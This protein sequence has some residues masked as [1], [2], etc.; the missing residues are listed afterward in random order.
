MDAL[1]KLM[2][3]KIIFAGTTEFAVTSLDKLMQSSHQVV[4]VYTQPDRPAGRGLKL[5]AS[6]I[7][8]AALAY[9]L[10]LYQPANFKEAQTQATLKALGAD[11]MVVVVY[12]LLLPQAVLET[13]RF[14]CV[15]LHPSLLP[16]WRGAAPVVRAIEAGDTETGVTIMQ[17]D[18]GWDTG[19]ILLQT[20]C[21]IL[22][23][24]TTETLDQR[25]A[26]LGATLLVEA[27][28]KLET[29]ALQPI[30]QQHAQANYAA[31]MEKSDGQ[32]DWQ[33]TAQAL[34]RKIRAFNPWPI[35][36]THWE[37]QVL[38]VWKAKVLANPQ[39]NQ[40]LKLGTVLAVSTA[41]IDV[42]TKDGVLRLLKLQLPG[43]KPLSVSDFVRARAK[44][45]VALQTCF[46]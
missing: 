4:A 25:L 19:D 37:G 36:Y 14:G 31:K 30:P 42:A 39:Q 15:N 17:L 35:A 16:R 33:L 41:G 32:I 43:G 12:G 40:T 11:V 18:E 38:R 45:L 9:Q 7:K 2:S 3:L 29:G 21:P 23:E 24:D 8:Q 44:Q 28:D 20:T 26:E 22:P 27:V 6:P 46:D 34:D 10:P 1:E 5:K 13:C